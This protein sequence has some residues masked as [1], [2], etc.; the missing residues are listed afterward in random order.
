M[1][2]LVV[3]AT[4]GI[5][6]AGFSI[7]AMQAL[8][9]DNPQIGE[10]TPTFVKVN[11]NDGLSVEV[12]GSGFGF[13]FSGV[14]G[15]ATK[16]VLL[17]GGSPAVTLSGFSIAASTVYDAVQAG[18]YQGLAAIMFAGA[19]T[20]TGSQQT[21]TLLGLG[22]DDILSGLGGND[23]LLRWRRQRRA[24]RRRG[25]GCAQRR[26]R[27]RH[28]ELLRNQ[29][30]HHGQ[31]DDRHRHRRRRPGRRAG[32]DRE[33]HRRPGHRHADGQRRRQHPAG[34]ERQRPAHRGRRQGHAHRRLSGPTASSTPARRRAWSAPM[35][36]GSPISAGPRATRSTCRRSTPTPGWPATRPSASSA[37]PVHRRRR[38]V[39]LRLH[40][41]RRHHHR[42][43]RQRR[44][45][46]GLPHQPVRLIGMLGTDFVL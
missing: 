45:G 35:P 17:Q 39:A 40:P 37:R 30:R 38:A 6:N 33:P 36:T 15:T 46:L 7:A 20:M 4:N 26:R 42:R 32:V 2:N 12:T 28:R 11:F 19:D 9:F 31:P 23:S 25:G 18:D 16:L 14:T 13:D 27:H 1:A 5:N 44:R 10:F 3:N 21:D 22:G 29:H 34:L 8:A 24:P 41:A 43:R